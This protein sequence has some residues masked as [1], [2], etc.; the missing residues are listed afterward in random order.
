MLGSQSVRPGFA[1]LGATDFLA[2]PAGLRCVAARTTSAPRELAVACTLRM[3]N[4]ICGASR[5]CP[6]VD[7]LIFITRRVVFFSS[8]SALRCA[9]Q[10]WRNDAARHDIGNDMAPYAT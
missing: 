6:N 8:S 2:L 1:D 3:V 9:L 5:V 4:G 7:F 10:S